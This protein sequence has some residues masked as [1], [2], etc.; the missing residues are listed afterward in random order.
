MF[1]GNLKGQ[2]KA[3]LVGVFVIVGINRG[4]G[5]SEEDA[6]IYQLIWLIDWV[7]NRL[8]NSSSLDAVNSEMS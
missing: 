8:Q 2:R 5:E 6:S 3:D 7:R 1:Y 4:H